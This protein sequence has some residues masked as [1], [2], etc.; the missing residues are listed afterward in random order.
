MI[1]PL[2]TSHAIMALHDMDVNRNMPGNKK[3][4]DCS[5]LELRTAATEIFKTE[6]DACEELY[7]SIDNLCGNVLLQIRNAGKDRHELGL[8]SLAVAALNIAYRNE[9]KEVKTIIQEKIIHKG[10]DT[11][12]LREQLIIE[13][14]NDKNS[15]YEQYGKKDLPLSQKRYY[16]G[17]ETMINK[18]EEVQRDS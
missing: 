12:T 7:G 6:F 16:A 15:Y 14:T 9:N 11:S 3:V 10:I 4:K 17:Q 5:N 13:Q 1:E 2:V 18:I 8:L